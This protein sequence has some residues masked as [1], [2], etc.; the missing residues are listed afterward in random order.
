MDHDD[1]QVVERHRDAVFVARFPAY[2]KALLMQGDR[3]GIVA[4]TLR[5]ASEIVEGPGYIDFQS[6][7]PV[8]RQALFVEAP[9]RGII[10]VARSEGRHAVET[11]RNA[12]SVLHLP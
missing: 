9:C 12:L 10:A 6:K 5:E 2:R 8:D 11:R 7:R 1:R 3:G 4:L